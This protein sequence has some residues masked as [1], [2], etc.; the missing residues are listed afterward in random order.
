M[1]FAKLFFISSVS[2]FSFMACSST[3]PKITPSSILVPESSLVQWKSHIDQLDITFCHTQLTDLKSS[4][5]APELK[6]EGFVQAHPFYMLRMELRRRLNDWVQNDPKLSV[7]CQKLA[8]DIQSEWRWFEERELARNQPEK[9]L[10]Q[11]VFTDSTRQLYS[12]AFLANEAPVTS[13]SELK[14]GDVVL[15]DDKIWVIA[16]NETGEMYSWVPDTP[17]RWVRI[18]MHHSM[19]WLKQPAKRVTV[20]RHWNSDKA[21]Q[22]VRWVQAQQRDSALEQRQPSSAWTVL[23]SFL[24]T[25]E[26]LTIEADPNFLQVF[27]WR[28]HSALNKTSP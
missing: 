17:I 12:N 7:E 23:A 10:E 14:N 28:N 25:S 11:K 9:P 16:K 2:F 8:F 24:Q 22:I 4:L 20:L 19:G 26:E 5:L 15:A 3:P 18:S 27:E 21:D 13:V 6:N 1:K